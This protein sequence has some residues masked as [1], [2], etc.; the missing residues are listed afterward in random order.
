MTSLAVGSCRRSPGSVGLALGEI[1]HL[2]LVGLGVLANAFGFAARARQNVVGVG[3]RLVARALLV[4]AGALHVVESVD[5]RQRRLDALQLHLS[6]LNA[7]LFGIEQRLQ[8]SRVSSAIWSRLSDIAAWIA[9]R[10]MTSR[11]ALRPRSS[12]PPRAR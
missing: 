9:V 2:G 5:H 12:P 10:L 7:R 6:D 3:L 8:Q 11:N 4:G 1:D